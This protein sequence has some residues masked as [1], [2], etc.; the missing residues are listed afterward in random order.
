MY[1]KVVTIRKR[2]NINTTLI[3]NENTASHQQAKTKFVNNNN[4]NRTIVI[5]FQIVVK[6]IL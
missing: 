1:V 4:N 3:Q 2:K 5:D 6:H